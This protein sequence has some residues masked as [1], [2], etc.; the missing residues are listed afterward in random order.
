MLFSHSTRMYRNVVPMYI[1][2]GLLKAPLRAFNA[3]YQ[4]TNQAISA[5]R[6]PAVSHPTPTPPA[7]VRAPPTKMFFYFNLGP[8]YAEKSRHTH[9]HYYGDSRAVRTIH[10]DQQSS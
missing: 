8:D 7:R 10:R 6:G 2:M 5:P 4:S 9:H 3:L 1:V